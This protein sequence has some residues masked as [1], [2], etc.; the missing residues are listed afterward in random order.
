MIVYQ[1][2]CRECGD[3]FDVVVHGDN[4]GW[5]LKCQSAQV[6]RVAICGEDMN[7]KELNGFLDSLIAC[8]GR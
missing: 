8:N 2:K 4:R 1:Y 5:C 3:E 7:T 6:Q